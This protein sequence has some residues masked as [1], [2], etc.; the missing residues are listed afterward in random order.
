MRRRLW[1]HLVNVDTR[2]AELLGVRPSL[3]IS[4]GDTKMPLNVNDEDLY[5]DMPDP[6]PERNGITP[7]ALCLIKC[8]TLEGL[9]KSSTGNHGDVGFD[10]LR[11]PEISVTEKDS[12]INQIE[13]RLERK[14]LRYCDP[15]NSLH[16]FVSVM[17]RTSICKV[18]LFAHNPRQYANG[19]AQV[20]QSERDIVFANAMKLLEYCYMMQ[21]GH[22]GLRKYMWQIGT[23]Y[24]WNTMLYILIELRHRETGSEVE[25]AW[26]LIG[27][28]LSN[29]KQVFEESALPVYKALGKWTL[30]V[31]DDYVVASEA[32]NL[33]HPITPEWINAIRRCRGSATEPVGKIKNLTGDPD[34]VAQNSSAD[35]QI[36]NGY[37]QENHSALEPLGPYDFPDLMSF[38]MDQNEWIQW[39]QLVAGQAGF[40]QDDGM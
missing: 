19:D 18:K 35:N 6:P 31:W 30:E 15:S 5:P 26:E 8:E 22:N 36:Q 23:S 1:W 2:I 12:I 25:K 39:E 7:I 17:I 4:Y 21:G 28:V 33:P 27:S 11:R 24:L 20:P 37:Y 40:V 3:D 10:L 9:G 16:M 34:L 13:D 14:Y 29:H 32:R 38:E